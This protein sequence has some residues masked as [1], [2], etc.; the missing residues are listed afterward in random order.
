MFSTCLPLT[1]VY[2]EA[3]LSFWFAD[4]ISAPSLSKQLTVRYIRLHGVACLRGLASFFL[5]FLNPPLLF[6]TASIIPHTH[7]FASLFT[8]QFAFELGVRFSE[9]RRGEGTLFLCP[10][11]FA[12]GTI[13]CCTVSFLALAQPSL[14]GE[15]GLILSG[16]V[17]FLWWSIDPVAT[18]LR[19]RAPSCLFWRQ[20]GSP[21]EVAL[22]IC[23]VHQ[24]SLRQEA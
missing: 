8:V 20:E 11:F 16:C 2:L 18:Y 15:Q 13:G 4:V 21:C 10:S 6:F 12:V 9:G 22:T 3:E 19:R 1:S 17:W 24:S 5:F 14:S 23:T 7:N